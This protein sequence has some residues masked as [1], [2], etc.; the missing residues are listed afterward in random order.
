MNK[1]YLKAI[2]ISPIVPVV[3][4]SIALFPNSNSSWNILILLCALITSYLGTL[5]FGIPT[6]KL[7]KY[8]NLLNLPLLV[9]SGSIM[10][11]IV[12]CIAMLL[13]GLLLGSTAS[14]NFATVVWGAIFG[15]C[16]SITFGLIAGITRR[17]NRT[18]ATQPLV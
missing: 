18:S 6:I 2:L 16:V 10:G 1:R 12:L 11:I 4:I 8:Y 5:L 17:L 9:L 14:F 3:F 13:L 15:F 7:L